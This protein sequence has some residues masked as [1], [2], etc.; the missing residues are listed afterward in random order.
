MGERVASQ[1]PKASI[2]KI[3]T[4]PMMSMMAAVPAEAVSGMAIPLRLLMSPLILH[5]SAPEGQRQ[6]RHRPILRCFA[7][8]SAAR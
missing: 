5:Q 1:T 3:T 4:V 7:L 6:A 2:E 8:A